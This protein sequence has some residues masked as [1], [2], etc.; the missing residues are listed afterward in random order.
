M[1]GSGLD[2]MMSKSGYNFFKTFSF[3]GNLYVDVTIDQLVEKDDAT[4]SYRILPYSGL[5][6][7]V[8]SKI[9]QSTHRMLTFIMKKF[10]FKNELIVSS[11]INQIPFER[12]Y[13]VG[14]C[15]GDFLINNQSIS[16]ENNKYQ[17][18][19]RSNILDQFGIATENS[20]YGYI[21]FTDK[22][23]LGRMISHEFSS[24]VSLVSS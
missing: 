23:M 8:I 10:V 24:R 6:K 17:L 15:S 20:S 4:K 18:D 21:K 11:F 14:L 1:I 19:I 13:F 9:D 3:L 12:V 2:N 16:K 5:K 7:E 22:E